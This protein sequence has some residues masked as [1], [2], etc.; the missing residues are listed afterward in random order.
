MEKFSIMEYKKYSQNLDLDPVY[1]ETASMCTGCALCNAV[2]S[3][4]L[5]LHQCIN[6]LTRNKL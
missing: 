1:I 2:C 4:R 5:P 3:S 6:F